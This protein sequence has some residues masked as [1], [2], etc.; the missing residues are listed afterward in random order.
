M[1]T[2]QTKDERQNNVAQYDSSTTKAVLLL[3]FITGIWSYNLD[4]YGY[5]PQLLY[6]STP[7]SVINNK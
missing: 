2:R 5:Y 6:N 1:R 7:Y 4:I 3:Q